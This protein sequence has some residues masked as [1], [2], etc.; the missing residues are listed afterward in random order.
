MRNTDLVVTLLACAAVLVA[1]SN[2][3]FAHE[4]VDHS[5]APGD[6]LAV[7]QA[8]RT[9]SGDNSYESVP[10]W[11]QIPEGKPTLGPTHGGIVEDKAGNIYFTMD[12][13]PH[14]VLVYKPD[15]QFVRA[16]GDEKLTGIHGLCINDEGGEQ[17][18]YAAHLKGRQALK[19]KLDGT[20]VWAIPYEKVAESGKYQ[21]KEQFSPTAIAVGPDG[22]VYVADGYGQNWI[23]R[24]DRDQKYIGSFG[25]QGTEPG[26]FK[27]CHGLAL[28]PRGDKPLL[29]V[30]DRENRRLQHFDLDGKF[31]K[32]VAENLR[33]P[34]SLSFHNG[35]VA[36]AELEARVTILDKDNKEV[37]HLGDNPNKKDWANYNV[38]PD[39]WKPGIF[40]APHGVSFD[41]QGNVYVM[42]WNSS[43]RVSK[44]K[45]IDGDRKQAAA[46]AGQRGVA[47]R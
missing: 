12:G 15:G 1:A 34:C 40:T 9:G 35:K 45:Q 44:F 36:I 20:V 6:A 11:C 8:V 2:A 17:F 37:A 28:D 33:R 42:D 3:A 14:A 16:L 4:G 32:V 27:T 5:H 38:P 22:S 23:H 30:A 25:G 21:K 46:P 24:F 31:V 18:L 39:Q 41:R 47:S 7:T 19:M 10:N 43:G 29:L 13:G 26:R